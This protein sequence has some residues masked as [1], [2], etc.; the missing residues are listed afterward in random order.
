MKFHYI[1]IEREYGSGGQEIAERLAQSMGISCYGREIIQAVAEKQNISESQI[2]YYEEHATSSF[3]YT[4]Y[5]I[6]KA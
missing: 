2:E 6:G 3:L 4:I 5:A 1:A